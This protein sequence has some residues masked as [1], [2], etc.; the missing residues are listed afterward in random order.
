MGALLYSPGGMERKDMVPR[1]PSTPKRALAT[2]VSVFGSSDLDA[3]VAD[4]RER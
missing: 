3:G 2:L 4:D 1:N